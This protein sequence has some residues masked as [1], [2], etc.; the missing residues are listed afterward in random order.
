MG[1]PIANAAP[2]VF[3]QGH[4]HE[5]IQQARQPILAMKASRQHIR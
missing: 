3:A 1:R 4:A 5:G 2:Q